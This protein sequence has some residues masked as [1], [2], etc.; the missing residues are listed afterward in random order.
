MKAG[1]NPAES[2]EIRLLCLFVGC[3]S[4]GLCEALITSTQGSYR[5]VCVC[6]C[7]CLIVCDLE[8][9]KRGYLG[10]IRALRYRKS[11]TSNVHIKKY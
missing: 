7:V 10:T 6:M 9:S 8:T 11:K 5:C 1:F 4:S 2:V 3:V